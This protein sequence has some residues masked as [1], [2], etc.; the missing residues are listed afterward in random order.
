MPGA[1]AFTILALIEARDKASE[2]M[3]RIDA[4]ADKMGGTLDRTAGK[5]QAAGAKIDESLLQTASGADAVALASARVE[6]ASAQM[7]A[8]T[9]A[10]AEAEKKLLDAQAQ[11]AAAAD[12]DTAAM[13]KQVAAADALTEAQKRTAA[14]AKALKDAEATQAATNEAAAAKADLAAGAQTKLAGSSEKSSGSL[15]KM[16]SIAGKVGLGLGIAA[17]VMVK[18]A[19]NFQDATAHLVTDAGESQKQ[20]G[21]VRAGIL[22]ISTATGTSA[23]QL[24]DA[25][26]HIES[27][28]FHGAKGLDVLKVAAEGAKVGGASLDTVGKTLTGTLNAYSAQGYSTTQMMN[29]LIATVGAG[30]MRM[31]DLASSL[32]SVAPAAAAAGIKFNDLGAAIATMTAQNMSAHRATQE[33]NHT[34]GALQNPTDVQRKE[35][36]AMGLSADD[37]SKNLGKRGLTGTIDL[38]T[39]SITSHMGKS[40]MVLVQALDKS[41]QAAAEATKA[42]D[43]MPSSMRQ[44]AQSWEAGKTSTKAFNE[45]IDKLPPA[46]QT[47]YRQF[48]T[49]VK[50]SGSFSDALKSGSPAAQTY[51]AALA[52]VMGGTVGLNAA[53]MLSGG[54]MRDFKNRSEDIGKALHKGGS[55]VDNWQTIQGTFNQKMATAK[56]SVENAGIAIGSG[57]LPAVSA[58]ASAVVKVAVPIAT[59][60]AKHQALAS[61]ILGSVAGFGMFVG[62]VNLVSGA[63]GKVGKAFGT[64]GGLFKGADG[65][66]GPLLKVFKGIGSAAKTMGGWLG[67]AGGKLLDFTKVA[68]KGIVTAGQFAAKW[69]QAG[70]QALIAAGRFVVVKTAQLA[71]AA[72]TKIWAAAQWLINAAMDAN[73]ITLIIIAIAALVAAVIFCWMHFKGFRDFWKAAWHDIQAMAEAAWHFL[74]GVFT[75]IWHGIEAAWN[76]IKSATS[77][78]WHWV[79][80][81]IHLQVAAIQAVIGWFGRLASMFAGWLSGAASAVGHGILSIMTWFFTLPLKVKDMF[82]SAGSWLFNAGWN[83]I[84]GLWDGINSIISQLYNYISN[85]GSNI[86]GTFKNVL[87]ILSP[88]R[89][90]ANEV[91]KFIPLGIAK[92]IGDHMG[93]VHAAAKA[94][95]QQA[96]AGA[97]VG[98]NV[99]GGITGPTPGLVGGGGGASVVQ[100]MLDLRGSQVMS[101][102][103]MDQ[104]VHKVG[105]AIA[106]RI[107]PGGG[108]R[109]AG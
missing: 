24:T 62:T 45:A 26:Y 82:A 50:Q 25:M 42:L 91:G 2:I 44:V 74:E 83:I 55:E 81:F 20:L 80:S 16:A 11:A 34:I 101:E 8:A 70:L 76:G 51:N 15:G 96:V 13:E 4:A 105:R 71:V 109:L 10:Q 69:A 87:S 77:A 88:S 41:K 27:A 63:I 48:Q 86:V 18:A 61:A 6:A 100:L 22:N 52:K 56:T 65:E 90:M 75:G 106:T 73:P 99:T 93:A 38:I 35:M 60:L 57:L 104:L 39:Q 84:K 49:L 29:A 64:L 85:I 9:K 89:V 94:A 14:A 12:G 37:L 95:G 47:L 7:A 59:W 108:V 36:Q 67:T 97:Q 40:G 30:D 54:Q 98:L 92:G 58:I 53:L 46:Q 31:Q 72:A 102:R 103:D 23:M 28:G 79:A 19:G 32:G 1:E 33:L 21:M 66:A 107:L 5:A 17:G 43:A 78:V 68:G 3:A